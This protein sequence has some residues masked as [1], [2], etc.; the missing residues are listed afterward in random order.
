MQQ[1]FVYSNV[2]YLPLKK[3]M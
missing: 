3:A 2:T 1:M